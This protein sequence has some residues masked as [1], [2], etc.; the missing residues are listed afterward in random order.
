M[1]RLGDFP[2]RFCRF[3]LRF[4]HFRARFH[5]FPGRFPHFPMRFSH[6]PLRLHVFLGR[7]HHFPVRSNDFVGWAI[8]FLVPMSLGIVQ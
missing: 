4:L 7:L 8:H 1:E 6:F 5:D 2:G 3:S